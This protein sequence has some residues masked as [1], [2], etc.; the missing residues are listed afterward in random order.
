MVLIIGTLNLD[1][2]GK[3]AMQMQVVVAIRGNKLSKNVCFHDCTAYNN[4]NN[5][6]ALCQQFVWQY[7]RE[8]DREREKERDLGGK[9][10]AKNW[11]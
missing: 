1:L 10:E 6:K 4:N 7:E 5:N 11:E 2:P 9:D 8:S 3:L